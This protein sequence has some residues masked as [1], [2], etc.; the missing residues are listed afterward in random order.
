MTMQGA[1]NPQATPVAGQVTALISASGGNEHENDGREVR[2][3]LVSMGGS[4]GLPAY[5]VDDNYGKVDVEIAAQFT[6]S[7]SA[8]V[9]DSTTLSQGNRKNDAVMVG[10][11]LAM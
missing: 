6:P 4:F 7:L 11:K 5:E 1:Y 9:K 10:L 2:A 3:A 8:F